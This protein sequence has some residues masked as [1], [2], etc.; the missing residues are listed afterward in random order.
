MSFGDGEMNLGCRN[1]LTEV[2]V[3][4]VFGNKNCNRGRLGVIIPFLCLCDVILRCC[5]CVLRWFVCTLR[6][7]QEVEVSAVDVS[8]VR[9]N[10]AKMKNPSHV[11]EGS[12]GRYLVGQDVLTN[13]NVLCVFV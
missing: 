9:R 8:V 1:G 10:M 5:K 4:S 6:R 3:A 2:T 11:P 13:R 7:V 12:F